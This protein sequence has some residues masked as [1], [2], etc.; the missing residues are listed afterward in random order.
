LKH[1]LIMVL[2]H[3]YT[4]PGCQVDV[5]T[6]C[7]MVAPNVDGALVWNILHVMILEPRIL[8]WLPDFWKICAALL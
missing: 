1:V 4:N 6:K 7:C 3:G 2:N 8:S 5:A